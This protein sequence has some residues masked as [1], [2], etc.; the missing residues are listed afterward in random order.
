MLKMDCM[1]AIYHIH[2]P[3]SA[4]K[5]K[6]KHSL[7]YKHEHDESWKYTNEG[8]FLAIQG[9]RLSTGAIPG[10]GTKIPHAT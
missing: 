2:I 4:I 1:E 5:I 7:L 6:Q 8:T 10:L 3:Y 9:L